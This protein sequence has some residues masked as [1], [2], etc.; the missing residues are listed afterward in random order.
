MF[1]LLLLRMVSI[2]LRA[3][4]IESIDKGDFVMSWN[5]YTDQKNRAYSSI[6]TTLFPEQTKTISRIIAWSIIFM[7]DLILGIGGAAYF[8]L[9]QFG[10]YSSTNSMMLSAGLLIVAIIGIFWLQGKIWYAIVNV[11]KKSKELG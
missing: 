7:V 2:E 3:D 1:S 5:P 4:E 9:L 8:G 6:L 10:N 11:I